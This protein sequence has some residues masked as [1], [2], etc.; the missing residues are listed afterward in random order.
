MS[1]DVLSSHGKDALREQNAHHKVQY[2]G[3]VDLRFAIR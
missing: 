2:G 1:A 3:L